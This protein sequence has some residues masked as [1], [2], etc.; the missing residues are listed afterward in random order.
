MG[1]ARKERLRIHFRE[2]IVLFLANSLLK[3]HGCRLQDCPGNFRINILIDMAG[4][5]RKLNYD[6]ES[7]SI[8][9]SVQFALRGGGGR[10]AAPATPPNMVVI[11]ADDLG[12]GGF[13]LHG[14]Q[15]D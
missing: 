12:Y 13:G 3:S 7:A 9:D 1:A 4:K 5:P 2:I 8:V 6:E 15:A 10:R 11:L 14:V